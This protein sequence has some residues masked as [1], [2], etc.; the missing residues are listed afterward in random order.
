MP[1]QPKGAIPHLITIQHMRFQNFL[2]DDPFLK[3]I[4]KRQIFTWSLRFI[5]CH[6][7]D[8][9]KVKLLRYFPYKGTTFCIIVSSLC[10]TKAGI[11]STAA[12]DGDLWWTTWS[13][14][15]DSNHWW[16]LFAV[17]NSSDIWRVG[18][19]GNCVSTMSCFSPPP[20]ELVLRQYDASSATAVA[21]PWVRLALAVLWGHKTSQHNL[22][23]VWSDQ[24]ERLS[25][26]IWFDLPSLAPAAPKSSADR[27]WWPTKQVLIISDKSDGR[28][29]Q[30]KKTPGFYRE[31]FHCDSNFFLP[32][33]AIMHSRWRM[34]PQC[35]LDF[36]AISLFLPRLQG[37]ERLPLFSIRLRPLLE[38][39]NIS[40]ICAAARKERYLL[41]QHGKI[42]R[43]PLEGKMK[44]TP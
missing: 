12:G 5:S 36:W 2:W 22:D 6:V 28:F 23:L 11:P 32:T 25:L 1:L 44:H 13:S 31:I 39:C 24:E 41:S 21:P 8:Q 33:I 30:V 38:D 9:P 4:C 19:E 20:E 16:L 26:V 37:N 42:G 40:M 17:V 14:D 34:A 15:I 18:W 29:P 35:H 43:L 10:S 7:N 3:R 27:W